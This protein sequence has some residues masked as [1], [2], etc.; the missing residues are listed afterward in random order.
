MSLCMHFC[1]FKSHAHGHYALNV[2]MYVPCEERNRYFRA[3]PY[4]YDKNPSVVNR[5]VHKF[6]NGMKPKESEYNLCMI[7]G[8][9]LLLTH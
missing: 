3:F 9:L 2:S 5:S 8:V 7:N 6:M 1:L 4:L